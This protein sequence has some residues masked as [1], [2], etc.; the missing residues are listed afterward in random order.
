M[1]YSSSSTSTKKVSVLNSV[2]YSTES[3]YRERRLIELKRRLR[4]LS[5]RRDHLEGELK[6]I[7]TA[8]ITLERQTKEYE[9]YQD[10]SMRR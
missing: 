4:V 2:D 3:G 10:L 6:A 1:T 7:Q 9:A 8:L 5:C